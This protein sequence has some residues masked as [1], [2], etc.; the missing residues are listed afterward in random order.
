V[1]LA[2]D[3]STE[4]A[5][6]ALIQESQ[7]LA[8]LTWSCQQNHSVELMPSIN[9][10]LEQTGS[11]LKSLSGVIVARGPGSFNGLRVGVSTAKG[12]AFSLGVPL[13]GISTLEAAAY[14]YAEI[15]LPVC[16]IFNAGRGEIAAAIYRRKGN[17]WRQIIAQHITTVD[18]LCSQIT[19]KTIFCGEATLA[20]LE[21][22]KDKL[23]QKAI[24]P[25]IVS[26]L[27]RAGFL[28][29]LGVKRLEAGDCDQPATLQPIYLRRP[30][31][32]QPKHR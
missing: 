30:P 25:P 18:S 14:Q 24:I 12:L 2:I 19:G 28:A 21:Q 16:P 22:I 23:G 7:V 26:R 4:T 27:R 29:E 31:I 8:E 11:S 1:Y 15:G 9:R 32:T 5:S 13:V 3:T 10:L 20:I 6:L 17:Q